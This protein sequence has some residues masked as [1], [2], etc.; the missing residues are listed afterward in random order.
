[1]LGIAYPEPKRPIFDWQ[2]HLSQEP[3]GETP[4]HCP[5]LRGHENATV[6]HI[7]PSRKQRYLGWRTS[8]RQQKVFCSFYRCHLLTENFHFDITKVQETFSMSNICIDAM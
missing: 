7:K 2:N 8:S 4:P 5:S 3:K 6:V 1:M